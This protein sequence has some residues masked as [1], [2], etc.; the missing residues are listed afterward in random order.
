[1]RLKNK[2]AIITGAG[3]GIGRASAVL[4]AS[5]GA[6][7]VVVDFNKKNGYETLEEIKNKGGDAIYINA[8]IR[9]SKDIQTMIE[10]AVV[11]YGKVDILYN[12]CGINIP[13]KI[14]ELSE[15]DWDAVINTNLKS[16]YL[17]VKYIIP[18]MRENGGGIIINTAGTFGFYGG[19][20]FPA[21][22][23][24]KGGVVN[25]TRQIALDYG[26]DNIRVNCVCPGF[27]DTSMNKLVTGKQR[28]NI[29][30]SQPLKRVGK[31]INVANAALFLASD[32]SSFITGSAIIVDGGQ[33]AGRTISGAYK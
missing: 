23:A 27:I 16:I 32:E 22:C 10:S 1:M 30:A 7:V 12:H 3:S 21:Y 26:K 20:E 18:K 28:E 8:D 14:E 5:E 24:S 25:L 6:K 17:A 31:A 9:D 2:I 4:F 13:G 15:E 29:I 11:T 33:L 19:P